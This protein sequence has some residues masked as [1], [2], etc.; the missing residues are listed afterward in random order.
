MT[1]CLYPR[2]FPVSALALKHFPKWKLGAE[3][4]FAPDSPQKE[5]F[6]W[7]ILPC[8]GQTVSFLTLLMHV[9]PIAPGLPKQYICSPPPARRKGIGSWPAAQ[10]DAC[11]PL[12][13]VSYQE[14]PTGHGRLAHTTDAD[15]A[16][17]LLLSVNKAVFQPVPCVLILLCDSESIEDSG[18]RSV[19]SFFQWL[20][21]LR[22]LPSSTQWQSLS[23]TG[24]WI[25]LLD[26]Y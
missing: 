11:S 20:G 18:P 2:D 19:G 4:L 26:K 3:L 16:V 6:S 21:L 7:R 24:G 22:S 5:D 12:P 1:Y 15:L 25:S 17:P 14:G 8:T 10:K 23:G 13:T 9:L